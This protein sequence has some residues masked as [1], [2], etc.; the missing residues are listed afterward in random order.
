[1]AASPRGRPCCVTTGWNASARL[2]SYGIEEAHARLPQQGLELCSRARPYFFMFHRFVRPDLGRGAHKSQPVRYVP[3]CVVGRRLP[4]LESLSRRSL[5]PSSTRN[6]KAPRGYRRGA[7]VRMVLYYGPTRIASGAG[8]GPA[9]P[10]N[11]E[12]L[13]SPEFAVHTLPEGSTATPSGACS[14][15]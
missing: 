13:L 8:A 4:W 7:F 3:A 1:M 12:T 11:S 14:T 5:R 6:G 10:T 9:I 15:P 2:R